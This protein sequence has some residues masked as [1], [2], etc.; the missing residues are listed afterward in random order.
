M[1]PE[2]QTCDNPNHQKEQTRTVVSTGFARVL[3]YLWGISNGLFF[4]LTIQN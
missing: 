4:V 2:D 1:T 3:L